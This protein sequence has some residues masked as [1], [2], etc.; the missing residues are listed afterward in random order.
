MRVAV[1]LTARPSYAKLK[2]V[3]SA[4]V[5]RGVD[6]QLIACASALLERY[7]RVVDVARKDFPDV[8][9]TEVWSVYEG[10]NL[11]TS[12]K[13]TGAL[14]TE[15]SVVLSRLRPDHVLVCADRH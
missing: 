7:G 4:L 15:L 8:E 9:V 10:A 11:L 3:L 5:A 1:V 12:A 6:V 13:E 2:P 14:L